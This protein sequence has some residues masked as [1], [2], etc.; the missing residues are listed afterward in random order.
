[1]VKN[2]TKCSVNLRLFCD[3]KIGKVKVIVMTLSTS[4]S[5]IST[6]ETNYMLNLAQMKT[7]PPLLY[8]NT[9]L[10][11]LTLISVGGVGD[12]GSI[13]CI[14]IIALVMTHGDNIGTLTILYTLLSSHSYGARVAVSSRL[15]SY[16]FRVCIII[17]ILYTI[18]ISRRAELSGRHGGPDPSDKNN[19]N[20]DYYY[21]YQSHVAH[22]VILLWVLFRLVYIILCLLRVA[23][24]T[25]PFRRHKTMQFLNHRDPL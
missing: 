13:I 25:R 5:S 18:I 1:M 19:D 16:P 14:L 8:C 3:S 17:Y 10:L 2:N 24:S 12:D 6:F 7:S 20:N 21:Y 23:K 22:Y 15:T 9:S 4:Y 11:L